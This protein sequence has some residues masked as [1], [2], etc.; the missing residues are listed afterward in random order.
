M[1]AA[2]HK[3]SFDNL[4]AK[5]RQVS[6]HK[7]ETIINNYRASGQVVP[8]VILVDRADFNRVLEQQGL[9]MSSREAKV[10]GVAVRARVEDP[11]RRRGMLRIVSEQ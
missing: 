5:A 8:G 7:V 2:T 6:I 1:N 11:D 9:P 3:L 4:K 10:R